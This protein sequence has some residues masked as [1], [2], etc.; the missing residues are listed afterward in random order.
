MC[1][2]R[3]TSVPLVWRSS[4]LLGGLLIAVALLAGSHAATASSV[5]S[6]ILSVAEG[7][8]TGD[9]FGTSVAW[10]GDVNGDGYDDLLIG[11]FRYPE[12]GSIGKAYLYFGGPAIDSVA[13]IVIN[14]PAGGTGWFGVSVASA[15]DF[16][17]D[18][19]ADFIIGAQNSGNEGKAFIYYGG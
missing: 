6:R 10:V 4:V 5:T 3:L 8:N 2:A 13:D 19:Y 11:A 16:N 7:E 1:R 14:P 12:I 17:G 15:G 9:F 18:S